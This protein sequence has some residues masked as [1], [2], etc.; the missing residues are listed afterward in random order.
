MKE[1]KGKIQQRV[2]ILKRIHDLYSDLKKDKR[3]QLQFENVMLLF[4][5]TTHN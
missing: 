1:K 3:F 2:N 4:L 5:K